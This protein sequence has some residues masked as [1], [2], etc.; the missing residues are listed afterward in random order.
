M[1]LPDVLVGIRIEDLP[2]LL[3][4]LDLSVAEADR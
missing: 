1:A 2:V 4:S 3:A